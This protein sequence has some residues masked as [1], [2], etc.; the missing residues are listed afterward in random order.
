MKKILFRSAVISFWLL[1]LITILYWPKITWQTTDKNSINVFAWGD[2]LDPDV[3]KDFEK[4]TGIKVHLNYYSSNEELIVKLKATHG[5]GYD[6]IIPSD[7][8]VQILIR[9]NLLKPLD[10]TQLHFWNTLNPLLLGHFYDPDNRYSIPF[11]WEIYGLGID[12]DYFQNRPL[13]PSWRLIFD[14]NLIDY[15]IG[16]VN[17]PI[18]AVLFASFYLYGDQNNLSLPQQYA[19]GQLLIQQHQWVAVYASFRADYL[20]ATKNCPVVI[21]SS[22]YIW[23]TMRNYP[24]VH[25]LIPEEGTFI[26]IENLGIPLASTKEDLVYQFLNYLYSKES[27]AAHFATYGFFPSTT[28]AYDLMHLDPLADQLI[29]SSKEQ[30]SKYHFIQELLPEEEIR[31]I[32][33]EVKSGY[34]ESYC[35]LH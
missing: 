10:K 30:F 12:K 13:T 27:S 25:F 11:E 35:E 4:T 31:N 18:E 32:W 1:L 21:A 22:S 6:L 9:E 15:R 14:P 28:H 3:V 34:S 5:E 23:R 24:Y 8:A 33:V 19:I 2:I 16:M 17:D 29:H 26:T 7:Y 20:L